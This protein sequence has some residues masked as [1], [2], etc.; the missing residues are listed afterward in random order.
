[1][2]NTTLNAFKFGGEI[3]GTN[4]ERSFLEAVTTEKGRNII[5]EANGIWRPFHENILETITALDASDDRTERLL[6][7]NTKYARKNINFVLKLMNDLTNEQESIANTAATQSRLIQAFGIVA[8]LIC[9]IVIMYRIFGQLRVADAKA[10]AAQRETQQIF[11]T[12]DQ[13]LFL[14]DN[15]F[16]MGAQH[17]QELVN[18]FADD[19][20][21]KRR[22][23]HFLSNIVSN[24]DLDN[25]KRYMKLLFDPHKKQTL[26]TD[27]NPLQEVSIQVKTGNKI[28]NKFL[29]FNFM[30]VYNEDVIERVL[31]SV[32]D[33]TKEVQLAKDLERESKRSEQQLEMVSAMMEADRTLMP[34]YLKNTNN[35]LGQVNEL[36]R[37]PARTTVEFKQKAISMMSLIH[38][39]KGESAALSLHNIAD[40]CHQVE[41]HLSHI[42]KSS[43]VNGQDFVEPTVLL[44][45]LMSYNSTLRALFESVLGTKEKHEKHKIVD[46]SHLTSY[47]HEVAS[48]QGKEVKLHLSGLNAP[49]LAPEVVSGIN[50]ISTQLIRN[51][52]SHGIESPEKRKRTMKSSAGVISIAL[53][54]TTQ[55]GYQYMFH[56]DGEGINFDRI[57]RKAIEKKLISSQKAG[58][59]TKSEIINLIFSSDLTT[60]ENTDEDKG[61]GI[62]MTS[63]LQTVKQLGGTVSVKTNKIIGTTFIVNIPKNVSKEQK[64]LIA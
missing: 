20:I 3:I 6:T 39:V 4:G 29:R 52:I 19:N 40:V 49:N 61:R 35:S 41:A 48:R 10:E 12:V 1:M 45:K 27:L 58:N 9:F 26:I 15:K 13:G 59:M 38:S 31:A 18:I 34:I 16:E 46:W 23:T 28:E 17:S 7:E 43:N 63:V 32:S 2:F 37:E 8:A 57:T 36:L 25:I 53:F 64:K 44:N 42:N 50:I 54:N 30:R 47:A 22:L 5:A 33:I 62:G 11:S 21:S 60:S 55:N 24:S 56:D 14:L 51:A